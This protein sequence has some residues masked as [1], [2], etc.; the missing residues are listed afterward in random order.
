M[1]D[2]AKRPF[3][4]DIKIAADSIDKLRSMDVYRVLDSVDSNRRPGLAAYITE[5]R[6]DLA[7]EVNG[8]LADLGNEDVSTTIDSM[9]DRGT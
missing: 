9:Y 7:D 8:S 5:S 6:S 4:F 1:A 2:L 3:E